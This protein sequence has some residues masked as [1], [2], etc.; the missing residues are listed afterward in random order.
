MSSCSRC[1]THE[2]HAAVDVE[3]DAARRDDAVGGVHGR[4]AADGKAIAPV[5]VGHGETRFDDPRQRRDVGDL[6]KRLVAAGD[7]EQLVAGVD[8]PGHAHVPLGREAKDIL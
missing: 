6:V 8:K 7:R 3:A 4:H 2:P 1:S 5:D